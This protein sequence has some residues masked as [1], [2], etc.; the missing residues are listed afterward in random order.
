MAASVV[1]TA[2]VLA[3]EIADMKIIMPR[4]HQD[5]RRF[6][7]GAYGNNLVPKTGANKLT[8]TGDTR[9]AMIQE[10]AR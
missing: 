4:I 5:R 10:V 8:D 1:Q 3:N 6:L 9:A 2:R 7:S